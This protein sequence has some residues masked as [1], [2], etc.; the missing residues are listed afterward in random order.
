MTLDVDALTKIDEVVTRWL[1]EGRMFTAFE[2]SRAVQE[3]GVRKRHLHLRD[4]VH[5]AIARAVGG[6]PDYA[7]TLMDVGAP[8]AAWV[9]HPAF[10]DPSEYRPLD[11]SSGQPDG[12]SATRARSVRRASRRSA[13]S[14]VP[15]GAFGT[16][17]RGRLCI[18]VRLLS[19]IG[20][21]P[22]QRVHVVCDAANNRVLIKK[23]GARS[24]HTSYTAEPHGNVRLTR[25]TLDL[26]GLNGL[27]GYAVDGDGASITVRKFV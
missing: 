11:R 19:Q 2:V 1:D 5:E 24:A 13:T 10:A 6:R 15:D 8:D 17:Q 27:P 7:R 9:Y 12:R 18:P 3:E 4:A 22:G 21:R 25:G 14:A 26:A 20:I 23:T 16:D